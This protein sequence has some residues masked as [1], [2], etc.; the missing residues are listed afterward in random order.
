MEPEKP[1]GAGHF[2]LAID[3]AAVPDAGASFAEKVHEVQRTLNS[4]PPRAAGERVLWPGQLEAERADRARKQGVPVEPIVIGQL[5]D[6]AREL[7]VP[8]DLLAALDTTA[9]GR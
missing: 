3:P 2:F 4:L 7:D 5:R 9:P 1:M 8:D 6:L